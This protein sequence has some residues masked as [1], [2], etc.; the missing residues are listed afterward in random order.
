MLCV[1]RIPGLTWGV[2]T[3]RTGRKVGKCKLWLVGRLV[4][5]TEEPPQVY[6]CNDI[7]VHFIAIVL[8]YCIMYF[9]WWNLGSLIWKIV[10][11]ILVF[12]C[13]IVWQLCSIVWWTSTL[14]AVFVAFEVIV[15]YDFVLISTNYVLYHVYVICVFDVAWWCLIRFCMLR[16]FQL[17]I[18]WPCLK[19]LEVDPV[20][21]FKA[22]VVAATTQDTSGSRESCHR[23]ECP[24]AH[25]E[26]KRGSDMRFDAMR[27]FFCWV[28]PHRHQV[29]GM[30]Y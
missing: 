1:A 14:T 7:R 10:V 12:F 4:F 25:L 5:W 22:S 8:L 13:L 9:A 6:V 11:V 28:G 26:S 17:D 24:S 16:Y 15:G 20:Q 2:S 21:T 19:T 23:H 30:I 29:L 3:G 27:A 18:M